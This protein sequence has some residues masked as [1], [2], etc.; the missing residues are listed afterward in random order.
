M[1]LPRL[2][3]RQIWRVVSGP[4]TYEMDRA[5]TGEFPLIDEMNTLCRKPVSATS[6]SRS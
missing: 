1:D 3:R 2:D 4:S 6:D 5:A